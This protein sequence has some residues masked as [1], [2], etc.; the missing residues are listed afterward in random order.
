MANKIQESGEMYLESILVLQETKKDVH[1]IDIA[2]Y[3]EYSKPSVSRALGILEDRE[4]IFIDNK[5]VINFTESG[6]IL[7][8]SVY[9]KHNELKLFLQKIGVS[10]ETAESDACRIEHVI[11]D[12]TYQKI[13]EFNK[14]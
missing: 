13:K 12:E 2:K 1:A 4:L 14:I 8:L 3:L 10:V 11:S 7:A 5:G 6:K 9:Q